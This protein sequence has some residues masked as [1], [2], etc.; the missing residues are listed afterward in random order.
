MKTLYLIRHAEAEDII[1]GK[2]DFER[3]LTEEGL[4]H[5]HN[6]AHFLKTHHI[7]PDLIISSPALR[8]LTTAKIMAEHLQYPQTDIAT[9]PQIYS[10]D[11]ETIIEIIKQTPENI[12]TLFLFGHNPTLTWLGHC[13]CEQTHTHLAP[14][15]IIPLDFPQMKSWHELTKIPGK[16]INLTHAT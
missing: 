5:T 1:A 10:G 11:V 8:A 4:Q 9:D 15:G 2:Q 16:L 7:K 3:A 13:L 12:S 6:K 14:C